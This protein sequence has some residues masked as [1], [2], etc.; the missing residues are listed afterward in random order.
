MAISIEDQ[1]LVDK[2]RDFI[3]DTAL[4]NDLLEAEENTDLFLHS[5]LEDAVDEINYW[6]QPVTSYLMTSFPSWSILKS[7]AILQYLTG[8]GISSA[9]NTF[10]YSDGSGIQVQDD[11]AWGRY[12]NYYN[13]LT[14][15]YQRSLTNFKVRMNVEEGYGGVHSEYADIGESGW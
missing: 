9:R 13:V 15:K 8:A 11:D 10:S 12:M 7:G 2:L 5:C 14:T 1:V 4:L 6:N 3:K